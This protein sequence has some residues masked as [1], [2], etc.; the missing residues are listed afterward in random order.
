MTNRPHKLRSLDA[1]NY[2]TWAEIGEKR[3]KK[4]HKNE[5]NRRR[6]TLEKREAER[7]A[8]DGIREINSK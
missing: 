2:W 4:S 5:I 1:V 3:A 6:R 8:D 7:E